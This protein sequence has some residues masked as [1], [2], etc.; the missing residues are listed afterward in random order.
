MLTFFRTGI[1]LLSIILA[2][3]QYRGIIILDFEW[4]L[5]TKVLR[6][7]QE[8][9]SKCGVEIVVVPKKKHSEE[10]I[11]QR[12]LQAFK[13]KEFHIQIIG[14]ENIPQFEGVASP[15]WIETLERVRENSNSFGVDFSSLKCVSLRDLDKVCKNL[16]ETLLSSTSKLDECIKKSEKGAYDKTFKIFY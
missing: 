3:P 15:L 11:N 12:F 2:S 14:Y 1:F 7:L 5:A 16:R 13:N 10:L 6:Y 8:V 4:P 9:R